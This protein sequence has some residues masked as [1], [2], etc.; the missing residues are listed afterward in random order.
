MNEERQKQITITKD[1]IIIPTD[2]TEVETLRIIECLC[3]VL[4]AKLKGLWN[5]KIDEKP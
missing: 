2:L 5:I 3:K 1:N 4:S